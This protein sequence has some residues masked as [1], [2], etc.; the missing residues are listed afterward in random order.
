MSGCMRLVRLGDAVWGRFGLELT[1]HLQAAN[2]CLNA[3]LLIECQAHA[4]MTGLVCQLQQ[5]HAARSLAC[6]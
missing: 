6:L 2:K 3:G 1:S 4:V 5:A